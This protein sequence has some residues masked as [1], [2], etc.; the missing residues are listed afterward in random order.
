L[1]QLTNLDAVGE[2]AELAELDNFAMEQVEKHH[3]ELNSTA[4][5]T[6]TEKIYKNVKQKK[7]GLSSGKMG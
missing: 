5:P 3:A 1:K 2:K 4:L 7:M 6:L